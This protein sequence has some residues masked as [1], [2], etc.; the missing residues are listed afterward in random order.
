MPLTLIAA[1]AGFGKTTLI[2]EF[3]RSLSRPAVWYQLDHT[4]ADPSVFMGYLVR[5]IRDR[6]PDFGDQVLLYLSENSEEIARFPERPADLLIN[7]IL[8]SIEQ[9]F[10]VVLDDY[11][12][13]GKS[14]P[15]HRIVDRL[16]TYSS[17]LIHFVITTRDLPPLT[18]MRRK[19]QYQGMLIT[20]DELLFTDEEV[21]LLFNETF[22]IE[23]LEEEIAAYRERTHGW[24]TALQLVRQ[25][26]DQEMQDATGNPRPDFRE[27]LNRSEK[28]IFDYFAEE[29]F[30]RE[31]EETRRT[32][33]SISLLETLPLD[34]CTDLFPEARLE[35]ALPELAQRNVFLSVVGDRHS[36]EEYRLHP[37]FRDFLRRRLRSEIGQSAVAAEQN[38][39]AEYFIGRGQWEI[40]LPFLV[41]AK[42][43]DRAALIIATKGDRWVAAGAFSVLVSNATKI[44]SEIL[45]RHPRSLLH[46]AEVARLEGN[47]ERSAIFLHR[48]V[49]LLRAA[50]DREGEAE[51]LH[52]LSSL[53]RRNGRL[54]RA[55]EL[56][57]K[58][59]TIV[60]PDSET[61]M[62]CANTRGLCLIA[63][64][65]HSEAEQQFRIALNIAEKHGNRRYIRLIT[66]NLALSP[67]YRGDF[68]EAL[69]WFKR[70]F[71]AENDIKL[72]QEAIG[73]LNIAR[74]HLYR[75]EFT[76]AESHLNRSLELCTLF[77]LTGL[78]G[79]IFEAF[80]NF[81]R[82]LG[83]FPRALEYYDRAA[84]A[85]SEAGIS[86][87]TR[88]LNE[89]IA[90]LYL[91]CGETSKARNLLEPLIA[92]RREHGNL[93]GTATAE[94]L[95]CRVA[96]SEGGASDVIGSLLGH[97]EYFASR[98]NHYDEA[99]ALLAL[100]EA[101][102]K[103]GEKSSAL[104]PLQRALDLS[105]RFDYEYWL[106]REIRRNPE[107]FAIEE[108]ADRIPPDLHDTDHLHLRANYD[109]AVRLQ[110][111]GDRQFVDL[112]IRVL[113][114]VEIAGEDGRPIPSRFWTTKRSRDIF[115]FIAT[116]GHR[117]ASKDILIE[118]FWPEDNSETIERNFHPTISHIRKALNRERCVKHNFI[119]FRDGAYLLNPDLSYFV[120]TDEFELY[121]AEAEK[122]R[123]E[124]D[125]DSVR[126][127]L[128]A[129]YRLYRGEF[130]EGVYEPWAESRRHY[131]SEQFQRVLAALAKHY[132]SD[133]K[134]VTAQRFANEL[135]ALDPYRE[136]IHRLVMKIYAV[137]SKKAAVKKHFDSLV[138][139]LRDELGIEPTQETRRL[140]E[141]LLR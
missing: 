137:Q 18:I 72:P 29:V 33:L 92:E 4:D 82:E 79:E 123:R 118:T 136:D 76:Q 122:S 132:F 45:D 58:A 73:H 24:V 47:S 64:G 133:K 115:C 49:E 69:R 93:L 27:I 131:Y 30:G 100:A 129:A 88:E 80:G 31:T 28:D 98:G 41:A 60:A 12:H 106:R 127:R 39:M 20:R 107:L 90:R 84:D 13:I 56:L 102:S 11:H 19:A 66:H 36:G 6:F 51:A 120:D 138:K 5:G 8:S 140:A 112:S 2:S 46:L 103:T 63:E 114:P 34:V 111:M 116:S 15:V 83:E 38:R 7:E 59:E 55:Y 43:Y 16:L 125:F 124:K 70:I 14:T 86:P 101:Y 67:G 128:E 37:L 68:A 109:T 1:D 130:M 25:I 121:I 110:T 26:A 21:R 105:A 139:L 81:H 119:V 23:L 126:E 71:S 74:L 75:G 53:E 48:S 61:A 40:A 22:G 113:G 35:T 108:I 104:P 78:R 135:L 134:F 85:Y 3:I 17:E 95:L 141:E 91:Q 117:R 57:T 9:P 50:G 54:S 52:S 42:N 89:E 10:L 97:V 62:R 87:A 65:K 99:N 94:L 44:P 96:I 77:N 32:L